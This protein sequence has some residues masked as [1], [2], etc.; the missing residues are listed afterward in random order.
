M[1]HLAA[2]EGDLTAVQ[3]GEGPDLVIL[4]SLLTDRTAFDPVLPRLSK[5]HRVTL[6]NL[7]GFHGSKP[8]DARLDAYVA[9]IRE[10]F[11]AFG[12]K[13]GATLLGN[14]FGGTLA[15]AFALAHGDRLGRLVVC[16]AAAG[17]PDAGKQAF[18]VMAEKVAAG[19]L[20]AI[21]EIAANRVFHAA[22]LAKHPGV[23]EERKAALMAID[24]A[25]FQAACGILVEADL[26]PSLAGLK[27]PTLVICGELD[28]AT[29]PALNRAIAS[30]VPGA[31]YVELPGCG[32]CPP[33]EQ[34][35]AFLAALSLG[36][37]PH[38]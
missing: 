33:L 14:G 5:T 10:G 31:R 20:G 12:I 9:R 6:F 24:P 18:R 37:E 16:D 15:L 2:A 28:Q 7:P 13:A 8:V 4:H 34:P 3:E 17:F 21:A 25:A 23:I 38:A 1:K 30:A 27:V 11:D 36:R 29:P 32:H 26:L 35:D 22:Y 19:G